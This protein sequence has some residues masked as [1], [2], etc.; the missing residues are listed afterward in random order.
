MRYKVI[1]K[2]KAIVLSVVDFFGFI[3]WI[4]ATLFQ[5]KQKRVP[6]KPKNILV[7][8][9]AYIGD[10][11]MTLPV[12]KPLKE[13]YPSAKITFLT[14]FR[15][16]EL[17]KNNPYVD[18]ILVYNAF[19]FYPQSIRTSLKEYFR[20]LKILRSKHYD[21]A[22][23]ARGD[24]RDIFLILYASKS[25]CRLSYNVGGGGYLLTRVVPY[26]KVKHRIEYHL[27]MV[28]HLNAKTDNLEWDIYLT[29]NEE[30][31]VEELLKS[32]G[33]GPEGIFVVIHPGARKRLKCW[34]PERFAVVADILID[35]LHVPVILTGSP[36][37]IQIV[38]RIEGMM[39]NK[40]VILAGEITLRELAG[41]IKICALFICNDSAPLHLA[42]MMKAPTVAI[43]GPSKSLETGPY[44]NRHI[45]VEKNFS[46]RYICDEDSCRFMGYNQCMKE[47]D[48]EDVINAASSLWNNPLI[49][50]W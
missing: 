2:K 34:A 28:R 27:D 11:V 39:K 26:K 47:I 31:R 41:L 17:L 50:K 19:W 38:K 20:F 3:L 16:I 32:E 37:E 15:S 42:S 1:N 18:E 24:I 6:D 8:R 4:P 44:G 49:R 40:P 9:T 45:C 21:L 30:Q 13:L 7:I 25:T 46:C 36:D 10:V 33:V 22:I 29:E 43:F 23:E 48:P 35:T 5:R 12:L 14:N